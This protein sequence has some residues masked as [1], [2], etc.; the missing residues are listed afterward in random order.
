[1]QMARYS[2]KLSY[3]SSH[4]QS[5]ISNFTLFTL[6]FTSLFHFFPPILLSFPSAQFHSAPL[7]AF[8]G[9]NSSTLSAQVLHI[10][11]IHMWQRM[12]CIP[13]GA[14]AI[15]DQRKADL[16]SYFTSCLWLWHSKSGLLHIYHHVKHTCSTV[17]EG[18]ELSTRSGLNLG[19]RLCSPSGSTHVWL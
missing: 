15:L 10:S 2:F 19:H 16:F 1:M 7:T 4:S 17:A 13:S 9:T 6:L 11:P 14:A 8:C 12:S 3:L 5:P 18:K